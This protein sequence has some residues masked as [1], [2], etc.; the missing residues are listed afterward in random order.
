VN[1]LL[2]TLAQRFLPLTVFLYHDL[3]WYYEDIIPIWKSDLSRNGGSDLKNVGTN[4]VL[5]IYSSYKD[6]LE[7]YKF[8]KTQSGWKITTY[9]LGEIESG[10]NGIEGIQ[11]SL[12][13]KFMSYPVDL[14]GYLYTIWELSQ[15]KKPIE[16]QESFDEL[17]EWLSNTERNRPKFYNGYE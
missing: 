17:G 5:K 13:Q 4:F 1:F 9:E 6:D 8:Q 14:G 15:E 11:M 2:V 16:V 12:E 7:D 10:K 3:D